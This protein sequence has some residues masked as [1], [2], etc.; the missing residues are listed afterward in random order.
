MTIIDGSEKSSDSNKITKTLG[1][2]SYTINPSLVVTGDPNASLF[3]R[4]HA[5]IKKAILSTLSVA[6]MGLL[7]PVAFLMP[8]EVHANIVATVLPQMMDKI[9]DVFRRERSTLLRDIRGKVLDVGAGGGAYFQFYVDADQVVAIEPLEELHPVLHK[10]TEELGLEGKL[11]LTTKFVEVYLKEHPTEA[12][13]F[14]WIVLG[15]VLCEVPDIR[16]ALET[17]DKL[18]KRGSGKIYFCEHVAQPKGSFMRTVQMMLN[19]WWVRVSMGCNCNRD[20]LQ[21]IQDMPGWETISWNYNIVAGQPWNGPFV[22]GLA[23][24]K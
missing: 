13:T 8:H 19:P 4:L 7:T 9:G 5:K 10:K 22:V 11:S 14:D 2:D 6:Q 18:L 24:K 12:G 20:T 1:K 16:S 23:R 15:N 21:L 17:C 3:T